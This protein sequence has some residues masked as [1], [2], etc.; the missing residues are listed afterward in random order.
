MGHAGHAGL[1]SRCSS[2]PAQRTSL[3]FPCLRAAGSRGSRRRSP[4]GRQQGSRVLLTPCPHAGRRVPTRDA[5]PWLCLPQSQHRTGSPRRSGARVSVVKSSS[6]PCAQQGS[7]RRA[8]EMQQQEVLSHGPR[9]EMNLRNVR[10]LLSASAWPEGTG[11]RGKLGKS[12]CLW[13]FSEDSVPHRQAPQ[14]R[15]RWIND[16]SF[17]FNFLMFCLFVS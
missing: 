4:P 12:P 7:S 5:V 3:R 14:S 8:Q 10:E 15:C 6:A 9:E 13:C 1:S 17:V 2:A 11:T 16:L